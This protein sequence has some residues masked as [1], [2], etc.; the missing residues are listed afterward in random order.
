M[1]ATRTGRGSRFIGALV[2]LLLM[3]STGEAQEERR[4]RR[5]AIGTATL[6][7]SKSPS[8][9]ILPLLDYSGDLWS[10]SALTGDWG[11]W[12]GRLAEKGLSVD[13]SLATAV[14][15][16]A[17]G[18]AKRRTRGGTS[19]DLGAHVDFMRMGL[20]PGG[21]LEVRAEGDFGDSILTESGT[22]TAVNW[23]ALMPTG[24][25]RDDRVALS[26][27]YY[28]QFLGKQFGVFAGRFDTFHDGMVME[29]AG[30]GPRA[31]SQGF[32]NANLVSPQ[33]VGITTPYVTAFGG[34][35][36]AKI[37]D[38]YAIGVTIVDKRESSRRV[39]L[40]SLGDDGWTAIIGGLGQ[41]ELAGLP[42]GVQ[43]GVSVAWDG[44]FTQLGE[45]QFPNIG[46]GVATNDQSWNVFGNVW[47]YVQVFDDAG[48]GPLDLHDG[49]PDRRGWGVF[50][51][52]GVADEDTNP[53]EW[54][55]AGGL[56]GRGVIP[57]RGD[58]VFGIAYFYNHLQ[59]GGVVSASAN[60]GS[61]EQGLEVFYEIAVTQWLRLTPDL[62][63]VGP[64]PNANDTVVV[65]GLRVTAD[66]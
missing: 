2:V 5:G 40:G 30:S 31:G 41:Y 16:V 51:I 55:L 44:D 10:R 61:Q 19:M 36:I 64:G 57:G 53:F 6:H 52:W 63:V 39:G 21:L 58:D 60:I 37:N 45:G 23:G 15:G 48:E 35:A 7:D 56:G 8:E 11:G 12:R 62:Q 22:I 4:K 1:C 65:W 18:G 50:A 14:Q 26:D 34:G 42:G 17:D 25:L 54:S 28:T 24:T 9:G 20:I 66:F 46:Q 49:R 33:M 38:Y 29:F 13:L 3:S 47:Q 59:T 43:V 27:L 32:M